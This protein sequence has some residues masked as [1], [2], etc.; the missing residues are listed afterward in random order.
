MS[1]AKMIVISVFIS[2]FHAACGEDA[3]EPVPEIRAIKTY[4]VTEIASGQVRKFTATIRA[5]DQSALSFQ[6][7]GN[8]LEVR[9]KQ[10]D[11]VK[12]GQV[13]AVLDKQE[14]AL[15][16]E[17]AKAELGKARA[18][19]DQ[20]KTERA[21]QKTLYDKGWVAKARLD[22]MTR[23]R[24]T[25]RSEVDFA[26]SKLNLARRDLRLT[27]LVAPFDGDISGKFI[28]P[29]VEV[30]VGQKIF[31]I[32]AQG[33]LEARFDIPET[34]ISQITL[35]I[36]VTVTFPTGVDCA[37]EA[38]ITEIGSAAGRANAFPVK[39][40]LLDPVPAIRSGM[41]AEVSIL[42]TK[43]TSKSTYLVPVAAIAPSKNANE[44]FAFIYE[45]TTQTVRRSRVK[46]RGATDNL[47][48]VY[49]G[50]KV[51]DVLAVAGVIFLSD[52]LKVKLL[53]P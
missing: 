5:M 6:V 24:D 47:A 37:C 53:T 11:R 36:P 50:V 3:P 1:I 27:T 15:N 31:L 18:N 38:R 16:V 12:K 7:S 2:V 21:R 19:L 34:T 35:G 52:G 30:R 9:V 29:H 14:Y 39:A 23:Q 13:L 20:K 22:R 46:V 40:G 42:L 4:T 49:E 44:G 48:H 28:D 25:A 26:V 32:E 45:P 17:G 43:D 10:G 51:G 33:T 8:V 41:T